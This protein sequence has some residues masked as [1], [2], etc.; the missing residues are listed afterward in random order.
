[1]QGTQRT[2]E[3]CD[4][5]RRIESL[6]SRSMIE[7]C[8]IAKYLFDLPQ[9]SSVRAPSGKSTAAWEVTDV[10]AEKEDSEGK[11]AE[12]ESGAWRRRAVLEPG[13]AKKEEAPHR[14][15]TP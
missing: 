15:P 9:N 8:E 3:Y 12:R 11:A 5:R 4:S 6:G 13:A 1:M 7:Y 14:R 10:L 2:I